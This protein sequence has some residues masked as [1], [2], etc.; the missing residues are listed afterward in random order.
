M[1]YEDIKVNEIPIIEINKIN[2]I[3]EIFNQLFSKMEEL[4]KENEFLK[5]K[6]E[7]TEIDLEKERIHRICGRNC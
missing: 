6:L 4:K 3:E 5:K 1:N 2:K 7:E